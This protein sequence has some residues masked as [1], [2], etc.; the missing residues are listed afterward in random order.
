M[1]DSHEIQLNITS[2]TLHSRAGGRLYS[3]NISYDWPRVGLPGS[4]THTGPNGIA[5]NLGNVNL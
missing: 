5:I 2:T 3:R 4:T 1:S